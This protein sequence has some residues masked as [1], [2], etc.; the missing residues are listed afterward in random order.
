MVV[1]TG[2]YKLE[3]K[4]I[5]KYA[6]EIHFTYLL[7]LNLLPLKLARLILK[8]INCKK[9]GSGYSEWKILHPC[10]SKN[11]FKNIPFITQNTVM[12]FKD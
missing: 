4:Y 5:F 12:L 2:L 1:Y 8:M 7:T 6:L 9:F 10:P 3:V 11:I